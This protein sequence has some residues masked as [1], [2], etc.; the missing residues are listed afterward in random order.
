MD[1]K[2]QETL[3]A[4]PATPETTSKTMVQETVCASLDTTETGHYALNV[5]QNAMSVIVQDTQV[6]VA[7]LVLR[8][9]IL[10]MFVVHQE[11]TTFLELGVLQL[12]LLTSIETQEV[13]AKIVIR[14]V[15]DVQRGQTQIAI[16]V[17]LVL[18]SKK[19]V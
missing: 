5:T 4:N 13:A 17:T 15:V 14:V 11:K 9:E 19:I 1:A 8:K 7:L 3:I 18:I 10:Q 2:E 16:P 12:A 6:E